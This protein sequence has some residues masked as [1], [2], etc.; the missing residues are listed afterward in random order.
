MD[1]CKCTVEIAMEFAVSSGERRRTLAASDL[2]TV[3]NYVILLPLKELPSC[4]L[5][6]GLTL[7]CALVT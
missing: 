6:A 2:K 3:R 1:S 5:D 7:P 4:N